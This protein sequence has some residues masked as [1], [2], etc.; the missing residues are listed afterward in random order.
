[1]ITAP[2]RIQASNVE[3]FVGTMTRTY[4]EDRDRP[5]LINMENLDA[6]SRPAGALLVNVLLTE[7]AHATI[8]LVEP[9]RSPIEKLTHSGLG[10]AFAQRT[11]RTTFRKLT[12]TDL[13]YERWRLPWTPAKPTAT[14][15]SDDRSLAAVEPDADEPAVFFRAHAAFVNP[16]ATSRRNHRREIPYRVQS[17][18][19]SIL[20]PR[21][22][23]IAQ[24]GRSSFIEELQ[25]LIYELVDNV[26]EHAWPVGQPAPISLVQVSV[27][28]GNEKDTRDRIWVIVLDTGP[29]IATTATPKIDGPSLK[30][31]DLLEGLV[32]GR[33]LQSAHRARGL[34]LPRVAKICRNWRDSQLSILSDDL[35]VNVENNALHVSTSGRKVRGTVIVARFPT[36]PVPSDSQG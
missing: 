7:L 31:R 9:T 24:P 1:M 22:C 18:L 35:R 33:F 16:H 26:A 8:E 15:Q 28:R 6:I 5:L 21:A 23:G 10:F 14:I 11:G 30:P 3:E 29:G 13:Q 32:N 19:Q 4:D 34:G 25:A 27:A 2:T 17:W 20:P 12:A 36:P